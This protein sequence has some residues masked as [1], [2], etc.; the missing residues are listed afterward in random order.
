[1]LAN[2]QALRSEKDN[3]QAQKTTAVVKKQTSINQ[4][5]DSIQKKLNQHNLLKIRQENMQARVK[6]NQQV[7]R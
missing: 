1:M 4:I 7:G 2:T 5:Q 3:I 6:K